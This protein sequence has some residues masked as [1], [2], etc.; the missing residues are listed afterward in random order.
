MS[1][2]VYT[3][4]TCSYCVAAKQ[5]LRSKGVEFEEIGLDNDPQLLQESHD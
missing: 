2:K 4:R 3:R 5:L 1:I